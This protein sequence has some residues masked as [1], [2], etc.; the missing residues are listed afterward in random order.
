MP[1]PKSIECIQQWLGV[2]TKFA[3]RYRTSGGTRQ[4][5][6]PNSLR[7]R[8]HWPGNFPTQIRGNPEQ[9]FTQKRSSTK[10]R[11]IYYNQHCLSL[12]HRRFSP[13]ICNSVTHFF[14]RDVWASSNC[15]PTSHPYRKR[16]PRHPRVVFRPYSSCI[17]V[18][19]GICI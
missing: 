15:F 9:R 5:S 19:H 17:R 1:K 4:L 6:L 8:Q 13:C 14:N 3:M 7:S 2:L 12:S 11:S 16:C 10:S 18:L